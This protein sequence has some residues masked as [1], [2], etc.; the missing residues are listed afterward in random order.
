[1]TW[2]VDGI[3]L[4]SGPRN[5]ADWSAWVSCDQFFCVIC[6]LKCLSDL[7]S[8]IECHRV[9]SCG[10]LVRWQNLAEFDAALT[11]LILPNAA[12]R[13]L[14]LAKVPYIPLLWSAEIC[15]ASLQ[16]QIN[17]SELRLPYSSMHHISVSIRYTRTRLYNWVPPSTTKMR[18]W[19]SR[20]AK[21]KS[22]PHSRRIFSQVTRL[23]KLT[24]AI[25]AHPG[26]AHCQATRRSMHPYLN[27]AFIILS[28]MAVPCLSFRSWCIV[29]IVC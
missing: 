20:D 17:H 3:L 21:T 27:V 26:T 19:M 4:R 22:K 10:C 9:S 7:V 13:L 6:R 11:C 5:M 14:L 16:K 18:T 1:M 24:F 12:M 25:Q 8:V 15:S 2:W 29:R 23:S 28:W